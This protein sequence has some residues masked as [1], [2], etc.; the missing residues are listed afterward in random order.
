MKVFERTILK[1]IFSPKRNKNRGYE[2]RNNE[3]LDNLYKEPTIIGSLKSQ[4]KVRG[5][6]CED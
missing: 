2:V 4:E 5:D 1:K 6:T 3:E